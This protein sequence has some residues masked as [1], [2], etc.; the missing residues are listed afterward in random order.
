MIR[1]A[2]RVL[3]GGLP[4]A[5]LHTLHLAAVQLLANGAVIPQIV[6]H[7]RDSYSIRWVPAVLSKPVRELLEKLDAILPRDVFY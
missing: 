1:K 6:K 3:K 7:Y 4:M 2:Q 5:A